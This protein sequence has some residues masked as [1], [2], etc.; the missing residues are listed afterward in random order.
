M[1]ESISVYEGM[2]RDK[3]LY[4]DVYVCNIVV[5]GVRDEDDM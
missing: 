3:K 5:R 4:E 2:L 1:G